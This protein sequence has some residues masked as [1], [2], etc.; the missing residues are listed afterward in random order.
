M[1]GPAVIPL[2]EVS[3]LATAAFW[4]VSALAIAAA[5]LVVTVKNVF[6]AAIFLALS[7]TGVAGIYFVL[8]AEFIGIVQV[9]VYVGAVSVLI[10]F[11]VLLVRD[12]GV[13][14][15][16]IGKPMLALLVA[17]LVGAALIFVGIETEWTGVDDLNGADAAAGL[18]GTYVEKPAAD[19]AMLVVAADTGDAGAKPGVLNDTT[20]T[21]GAL[22]LREYLLAFEVI[23]VVLAAALI[24]ALAVMRDR[25]AS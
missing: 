7:F 15:R 11:A 13:G 12:V 24:G 10:A 2:F 16:S 9:L 25:R 6:R 23:G 18:A 1:G 3:G 5:A 8:S 21:L 22:L 14:N 4:C 19:G 20:G 17:A